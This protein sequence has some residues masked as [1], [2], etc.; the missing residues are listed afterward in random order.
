MT[1]DPLEVPVAL[2]DHRALP[3]HVMPTGYESVASYSR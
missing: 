3:R 2:A 1:N